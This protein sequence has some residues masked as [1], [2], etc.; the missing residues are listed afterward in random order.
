MEDLGR[1]RQEPE[2]GGAMHDG[3]G[4]GGRCVMR[5][6]LNESIICDA[7]SLLVDTWITEQRHE[8]KSSY[9]YA[10]LDRNGRGALTSYTGARVFCS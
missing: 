8:E 3:A 9:R 6:F 10:E 1:I 2:V 5:R 7:V 4:V